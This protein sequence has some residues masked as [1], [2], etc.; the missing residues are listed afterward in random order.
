M[1]KRLASI[2]TLTFITVI[3][4][5]FII[6]CGSPFD[7]RYYNRRKSNTS[8]KD[9]SDKPNIGGENVVPPDQDPF[10]KGE[11]NDPNYNGFDGS[12]FDNWF[13]KAS[14][15]NSNVPVYQ[16]TTFAGR[17]WIPENVQKNEESF[18]AGNDGNTA[19]GYGINPMT[20]YKYKGKNP[21]V[22]PTSE[23]NTSDRMKRFYFYRFIGKSGIGGIG[24]SLDNYLIA[25]DSYSK[26]IFVFGA[27]TKTETLSFPPGKPPIP[28]D[29]GPIESYAEKR[30]F[31]EY[32]PIG[33]VKEDGTVEL[34]KKYKDDMSANTFTPD[35]FAPS[36][37]DP[38]RDIATYGKPGRSPYL[39]VNKDDIFLDFAK[40]RTYSYREGLILY[41]YKFSDDGKTITFTEETWR[42]G[43]TKTTIFTHKESINNTQ[44]NYTS[45]GI[46]YTF[47]MREENNK[48]KLYNNN[49]YGGERN[50]ADKGPNFLTRVKG[51]T[52]MDGRK[53][54]TF[55]DDGK[56]LKY[57]NPDAGIFETKEAT[58]EFT[59]PRDGYNN[60]GIYGNWGIMLDP[61]DSVE[62]NLLRMMGF[63]LAPAP[64]SD[65]IIWN[66]DD[67]NNYMAY[68]KD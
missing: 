60:C 43:N 37:V 9:T 53:S 32:D 26:L 12:K 17:F 45:N 66:R 6:S 49:N 19:Q 46:Q 7:A 34:Y 64:N 58:Y 38:T 44:A 11:W 5:I 3:V 63:G 31:Y 29:W 18:E 16:F 48:S 54:Y 28:R 67:K 14:F 2:Y 61:V 13:I 62:D 40:K 41:T 42:T 57:K 23:Y 65:L 8:E 25:V 35:K 10:I 59:K 68:R 4:S 22:S 52:F 51:V 33:I 20:I 15:D 30:P 47:S 24:I 1:I 27:I 21:L 39:Y 56:I 36:I 55:S 50:F